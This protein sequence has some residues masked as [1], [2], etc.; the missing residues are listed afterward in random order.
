[1]RGRIHQP[2][3]IITWLVL[4]LCG[5]CGGRGGAGDPGAFHEARD[6]VAS[7]LDGWKA[8]R[9]DA[10]TLDD[11][12]A[13]S[14]LKLVSYEIRTPP[15]GWTPA[16]GLSATLALKDAKGRKIVRHAVYRVKD[17][18]GRIVGRDE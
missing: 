3:L 15:T 4:C 10:A 16:V 1:M 13:R 7:A 2:A 11:P 6:R 5:G 14:G 12:D 9:A 8:G 17:E 18:P